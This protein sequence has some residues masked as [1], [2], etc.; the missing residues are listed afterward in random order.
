[1]DC[2]DSDCVG[3][4]ACLEIC[5]DGEDNDLDGD[6]DCE[7]SDCAEECIEICDDVEDNDLDGDVDCDDS[8]CETDL[9]CCPDDVFEP[10]QGVTGSPSTL[11]D[12]YSA[13]S[14]ETLTIRPGDTDSFRVPLC[15]GGSFTATAA[16][17]HA[18]GDLSLVLRS[19][20]GFTLASANSDTDD[21]VL[22]FDPFFDGDYFLQVNIEDE[23]CQSYELT[24]E[25]ACP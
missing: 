3:T 20:F 15:R 16:F 18:A 22:E 25:I 21:E 2:A 1:M 9:A 12:D 5:G 19:R 17:E 13:S 6:V 11:W 8:D 24:L 14:T 23:Q 7:D 4:D 10:N